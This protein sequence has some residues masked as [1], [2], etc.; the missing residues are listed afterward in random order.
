MDL[1]IRTLQKQ[2]YPILVSL[3]MELGYQITLD[4][5]EKQYET[6]LLHPD[7]EILVVEK[8]NTVVGFAGLCIAYFFE[9]P[10]T[11]TRILAFVVSESVRKQGIGTKLLQACEHWAM[12][13]GCNFITLNSGNRAEREAAHAFYLENGFIAKSTGFAKKIPFAN[14]NFKVTK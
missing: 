3:I 11:Y 6:L 8:N 2:D 12:E 1:L 4:E 10:G 7:Y 14:S 9:A 13:Q 5:V